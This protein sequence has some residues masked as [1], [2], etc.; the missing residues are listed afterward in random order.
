MPISICRV[1]LIILLVASYYASWRLSNHY[2]DFRFNKEAHKCVD[3]YFCSS[4]ARILD[5]LVDH[6]DFDQVSLA[7]FP[8]Q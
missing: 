3:T 7:T 6:Y 8:T 4:F 5:N 2:E 1:N